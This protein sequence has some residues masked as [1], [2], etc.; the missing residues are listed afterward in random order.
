MVTLTASQE[1]DKY[2]CCRGPWRSP[3]SWRPTDSIHQLAGVLL[4]SSVD[5]CLR[6]GWF[7]RLAVIHG[8]TQTR[9]QLELAGLPSLGSKDAGMHIANHRKL[10]AQE[11]VSYQERKQL[12]RGSRGPQSLL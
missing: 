5:C 7:L 9:L 1:N 10:S 6:P 11:N 3:Y 12:L 2:M 8:L 4:I